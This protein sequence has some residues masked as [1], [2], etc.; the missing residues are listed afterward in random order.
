MML[1]V[2]FSCKKNE[3]LE[4]SDN[5][6]LS[7]FKVVANE[8]ALN[9]DN[10]SLKYVKSV[11]NRYGNL[12][13]W[14]KAILATKMKM[15]KKAKNSLNSIKTDYLGTFE[16][17]NSYPAW[18]ISFNSELPILTQCEEAGF[19]PNTTQCERFGAGGSCAMRLT[20]GQVDQSMQ[21]YLDEEQV[22]AGFFLPCVAFALSR[23]YAVTNVENELF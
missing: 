23:F 9:P 15:N 8:L 7:E 19:F 10:F 11:N 22:D 1:G 16:N 6:L 18:T 17:Y 2:I 20:S 13:N 21:S 12:E 3:R 14:K 5:L 4:T